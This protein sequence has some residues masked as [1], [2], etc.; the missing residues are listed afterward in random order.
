[1]PGVLGDARGWWTTTQG[2]LGRVMKEAGRPPRELEPDHELQSPDKHRMMK[3]YGFRT[4]YRAPS[5][6]VADPGRP[7]GRPSL[8]IPT[9][10]R[11]YVH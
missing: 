5:P 9:V 1:M 8:G 10:L 4:T 3:I 11:V 7:S 2:R 6:S